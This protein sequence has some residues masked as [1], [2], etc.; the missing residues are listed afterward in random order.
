MKKTILALTTIIGFALGAQAAV[1]TAFTGGGA[2]APSD[3]V[4]WTNLNG[5]VSVSTTT[6]GS[7]IV[8]G[9]DNTFTAQDSDVGATLSMGVEA[10][11]NVADVLGTP[12]PFVPSTW[13]GGTA[14]QGEIHTTNPGWGVDDIVYPDGVNGNLQTGEALILTFNFSGVSPGNEVKIVA[15][16]TS[17]T[18]TELWKQTSATTGVQIATGSAILTEVLSDGD[19]YALV[20]SGGRLVNLTLD[21]AAPTTG[22]EKPTGLSVLAGDSVALLDWDADTTGFLDNYTVYRGTISGTN[23][24]SAIT[25]VV[26]SSFIDTGLV[27]GSTY[28]YAVKAVG[29]TGTPVES[30]FSD[31]VSATP[32]DANSNVVV[33]QHLDAT[34]GAS[35]TLSNVNEVI[36]WAD[37]SGNGNDAEPDVGIVRWP[38]A[39]T[40]QSGLSGM[41]MN[42]NKATLNLFSAAESEAF[43]DFTG[44]AISNNGFCAMVAFKNDSIITNSGFA[45]QVILGNDLGAFSMV[46][47]VSGDL[48]V[49]A[50][51]AI[52]MPAD[53]QEG[54][55]VIL[56]MNYKANTGQLEF[57]NSKMDVVTNI[58][59]EVYGD[60]T[61]GDPVRLGGVVNSSRY[62]DGMVGEV[63]IFSSY[64]DAATF[65]SEREALVAQWGTAFAD[66]YTPWAISFGLT[67]ATLAAETNDL[68]P[69][70][71]NNLL[72]YAFGGNPTNDDAAAVKPVVSTLVEGGTNWFYH[73]HNERDDDLLTY[74]VELDDNLVSAPG[75][76]NAG[77]EFVGQS[78]FVGD[79]RTVTNRTDV[80]DAEFIRLNVEK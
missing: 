58:T 36:G 57:W 6:V 79:I 74:T 20:G 51:S 1:K 78:A 60:F 73:V 70:G 40:S 80:G 38:S 18:A 16:D 17:S 56:A 47:Q 49:S 54:D 59:A 13:S 42:T 12:T 21:I 30:D 37:Q 32:F 4:V 72:E 26:V 44:G 14:E 52:S 76:T 9:V 10:L 11:A 3:T 61:S 2:D 71:L 69:D 64:L 46:L 66:Q 15:I 27:N 43:L 35:V 41:D 75:W 45:N 19:S 33:I 24:Y 8:D 7:P 23:N 29:A 68:E 31:E 28:Y 25:N 63:K 39:S 5:T 48:E 50:G 62:I 22:V 65:E 34:I 77:I 67:N 55:T 53:V